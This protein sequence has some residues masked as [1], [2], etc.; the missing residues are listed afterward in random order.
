[1]EHSYLYSPAEVLD[2]FDVKESSGLSQQQVSQSRKK[3]GP[4][5]MLQLSFPM[6]NVAGTNLRFEPS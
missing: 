1:M 2:H 6:G 4:N 3:Y 5:G